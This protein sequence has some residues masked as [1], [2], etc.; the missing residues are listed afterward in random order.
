VIE[1]S[2]RASGVTLAAVEAGAG[3]RPLLL[4]HGFTGA[5]EDFTPWLDQLASLG[6]HAVAFDNRGHGASGKPDDAASYSFALMV[7]DVVAVIAE[8][9]WSSCT[10]LGHSMGGM[11]AQMVVLE[12]PELIDALVLMDTRHA[13]MPPEL[14]DIVELG[15]AVVHAEGVAGLLAAMAALGPGDDPGITGPD[16]A[17]READPAYGAWCDS[18]LLASAPAMFTAMTLEMLTTPDRLDRLA[19]AVSVPTLVIVGE[20]DLGFRGD[21]KRMAEAIAGAQLAVIAGGGHCPQFEAPDAWW[22][23]LSTFLAQGV[24]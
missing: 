5:K 16:R 19:A 3:G 17:L 20:H 6:W 12:H 18:K 21:S 15:N 22:A 9:G 4:V 10:M 7:A 2:L 1:R 23:A 11:V 14:R 13:P 8:L 24:P